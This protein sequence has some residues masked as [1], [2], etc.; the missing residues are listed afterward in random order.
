M[1]VMCILL[2][3]M[4][5]KAHYTGTKSTLYFVYNVVLWV[6]SLLFLSN[7]RGCN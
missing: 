4:W 5:H 6:P 1:L 7:L 3:Q 2:V